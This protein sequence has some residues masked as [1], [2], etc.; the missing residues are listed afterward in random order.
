M[1]EI[2]GA[3]QPSSSS[4]LSPLRAD[5]IQPFSPPSRAGISRMRYFRCHC[6]WARG[7]CASTQRML[8]QHEPSSPF[9]GFVKIAVPDILKSK[10]YDKGELTKKHQKKVHVLNR[11]SKTCGTPWK[12]I[13]AFSN[14]SPMYLARHHWRKSAIDYV[15]NMRGRYSLIHH[16]AFE[17]KGEW[18]KATGVAD[19]ADV[20][21][22]PQK[23][24]FLAPDHAKDEWPNL[25]CQYVCKNANE[26]ETRVLMREFTQFDQRSPLDWLVKIES[27][28]SKIETLRAE[29]KKYKEEKVALKNDIQLLGKVKAEENA[30]LV[31]ENTA[32]RRK[33][34]DALLG[35]EKMRHELNMRPLCD[36]PP[37]PWGGT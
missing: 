34:K 5:A 35:K 1:D 33:L 7:E 21:T 3:V 11:I 30:T 16:Y 13:C 32:L 2:D 14:D 19:A 10:H 20:F 37:A 28:E 29:K 27:K 24:V 23:A 31:E 9:I 36:D 15:E 17:S 12:D 4:L 6:K 18:E 22:P 25:Y 26:K 8:Q